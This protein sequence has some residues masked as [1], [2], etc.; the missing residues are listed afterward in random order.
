MLFYTQQSDIRWNF[1]HHQTENINRTLTNPAPSVS[2]FCPSSTRH[3]PCR[4]RCSIQLRSWKPC[5][6]TQWQRVNGSTSAA[7]LWTSRPPSPG[8]GSGCKMKTGPRWRAGRTWPWLSRGRA[9]IT[10]AS[11]DGGGHRGGRAATT[12]SSSS[13]CRHQ[14]GLVLRKTWMSVNVRL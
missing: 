10:A 9:G 2:R 12:R 13:P 5:R 6:T 4:Q 3:L 11:P 1:Y 7:A 14:V 8:H